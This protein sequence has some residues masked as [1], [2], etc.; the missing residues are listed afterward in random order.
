MT[1]DGENRPWT[2]T[3]KGKMYSTPVIVNNQIVFS[4]FQGDHLLAGYDFAGN[5]DEKWNSVA[6]K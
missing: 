1:L 5:L 6:P 4:T 2:R 3:L